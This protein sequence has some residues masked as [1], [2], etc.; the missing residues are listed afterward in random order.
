MAKFRL[1]PGGI[2]LIEDEIDSLFDKAKVRFLGPQ[3]VKKRILVTY[4]RPHGLAGMYEA[5]AREGM[6]PPDKDILAT[7]L[8]IA[9]N[10][11]E[12]AKMRAKSRVLTEIQS[13]LAEA[14]AAGGYTEAQVVEAIR[15]SLTDVMNEVTGHV[16]QIVE[17]ETNA[18]KNTSI[19]ESITGVNKKHGIKD[20]VVFFVVVNDEALC[21]ECKKLHLMPDVA[22]PRLWYLSEVTHAYHSRGENFPSVHGLHP[23]CRCT[24]STLMPG[25]GFDASGNLS[26]KRFGHSE[27]DI[28][29]G[30]EKTDPG[31]DDGK[32]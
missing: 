5:A 12:S 27:I 17:A 18:T 11:L 4:E 6:V 16:K 9:D 2:K 19:Y 14:E 10:Y 1:T 21:K 24:I 29:R 28:Q 32:D 23:S 20:P 25:W 8:K 15:N 7:L 31:S 26:F 3:S 30:T 13:Q 22:T